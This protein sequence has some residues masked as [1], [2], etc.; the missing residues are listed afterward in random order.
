VN[1]T[2]IVIAS[3]LKKVCRKFLRNSEI[4]KKFVRSLFDV[5]M[6]LIKKFVRHLTRHKTFGT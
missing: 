3:I 5:N 1:K 4:Y 2:F 6:K